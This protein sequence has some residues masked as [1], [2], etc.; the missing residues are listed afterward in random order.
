[1]RP[2]ASPPEHPPAQD[3]GPHT[4]PGSGGRFAYR[5]LSARV[6]G[7]FLVVGT[8]LSQVM[9]TADQVELIVALGSLAV[10]LLINLGVAVA[11]PVRPGSHSVP[12][13]AATTT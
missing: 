9:K 3:P 7:G 8:T 1:M 11:L 13:L 4:L 2:P 12:E 6:N 5:V 10:V